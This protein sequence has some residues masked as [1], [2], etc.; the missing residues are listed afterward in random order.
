MTSINDL[1]PR[2][3]PPRSSAL[4][5]S[6]S[7]LDKLSRETFLSL[8]SYPGVCR[9]QGSGKGDRG[10]KEVCDLLVVF[11]KDILIFSDKTC[12]F[13]ATGDLSLDW[14][15]WYQRAIV[16][17]ARQARGAE[18]WIR[19]HPTRL[20]LDRSCKHPFPYPL[21]DPA[22]AR[23][24][25]IVVASG[26]SG[27]CREEL[28]GSGSLMLRLGF[29]EIP[30]LDLPFSV[31]RP[32]GHPGLIHVFDEVTLGVVLRA[33]DTVS[34]LVN[35]LVAKERL[36]STVR[37]VAVPGE[38]DLLARYLKHLGPSGTHDF[39]F[40]TGY[41]GIMIEEGAW[42]ELAMN[43]QWLAKLEADRV[44]YAWDALIEK[45]THYYATG[46][47]SL[48]A[49]AGVHG[50]EQGLRFLARESRVRRRML[51]DALLQNMQKAREG[52]ERST[53]LVIP[54][55]AGD[56][57]YVFLAFHHPPHIPE[58]RYR[59]T[60]R[61][62]LDALA[63]ATRLRWPEAVDIVGI[64]TDPLES[65]NMS[66]DLLYLDGREWD[67]EAVAEAEALQRH[68]GLFTALKFGQ[69]T[70]KEYPEPPRGR[71]EPYRK[72][73]LQFGRND[74]CPCRSG[75]KFKRCCGSGR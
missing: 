8:W 13:P 70:A 28:G 21:P 52:T 31:G 32:D 18:R 14:K 68:F 75:K 7:R 4:T 27:R 60:R 33:L 15:R 12:E 58:E 72:A 74:P 6:E 47:S 3:I 40:P 43:P 55:R 56:P 26:A 37:M 59:I 69:A 29:E 71:R 38:E 50:F 24:H 20:F 51:A 23:F 62:M 44:S 54:T 9:D 19:E 11:E 36:A 5:G 53:R 22:S 10:A 57:H 30:G 17:S 35:Y 61:A 25:R 63:R 1:P 64:G 39:G 46:E 16:K 2:R 73:G 45:F 42:E 49:N 41:D 67:A 66:E 65:P 48:S 34:D